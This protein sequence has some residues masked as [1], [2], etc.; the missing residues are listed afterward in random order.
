MQMIR[1]R[2]W[3]FRVK[4]ITLALV[5]VASSSCNSR[6]GVPSRPSG[7]RPMTEDHYTGRQIPLEDAVLEAQVV[8]IAQVLK[9]GNVEMGGPG[10]AYYDGARIR[11]VEALAGDVTPELTIAYSCQTIPE[12]TFEAKLLEGDIYLFFLTLEN[13]GTW[14]AKKIE[15]ASQSKEATVKKKLEGLSRVGHIKR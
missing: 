5:L 13:G 3:H 1:Y 2:S 11:V 12:S 9:S 8:V 14:R 15:V 10:E 6:V 4:G 7:E